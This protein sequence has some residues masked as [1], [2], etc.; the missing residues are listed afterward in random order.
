[1]T[2]TVGPMTVRSLLSDAEHADL[3]DLLTANAQQHGVG[4]TVGRAVGGLGQ[5]GRQAVCQEVAHLADSLLD[6]DVSDVLVHAWKKHQ[7]LAAACQRTAAHPAGEE[8]VRL[9]SHTIRSTHR[10][11]VQVFV[12]DVLVTTVD[13]TLSLTFAVHGLLAVV[14]GGHI[15]GLRAGTCAATA[16]LD[17][18]SVRITD[19]TLTFDIPGTIH[20]PTE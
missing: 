17:C 19:S 2:T 11:C 3:Q 8:L 18:E 10:P 6:L 7:L 14:R 15:V 13:L 9:A 5:A 20:L 16:A 12:D 4:A 1:M